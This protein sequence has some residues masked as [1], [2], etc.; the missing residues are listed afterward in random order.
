MGLGMVACHPHRSTSQQMHVPARAPASA[1][2]SLWDRA[3]HYRDTVYI[4]G[5]YLRD[6]AVVLFSASATQAE[7][8]AAI[9]LVRG[10]VVGG[11]RFW[12]SDDGYY[13]VRILGRD[14]PRP[15]VEALPRLRALPQVL[16]ATPA[17]VDRGLRLQ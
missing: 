8:Q 11:R 7:R 2:G 5:T 3:H 13:Y 6:I 4:T 12:N 1:P 17:F 9:D 14:Y 10:E 16:S 15:L